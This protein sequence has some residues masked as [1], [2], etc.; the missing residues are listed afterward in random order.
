MRQLPRTRNS[1]SL[2]LAQEERLQALKVE[3]KEIAPEVVPE[4]K[5]PKEAPAEVMFLE[6]LG[7]FELRALKLRFQVKVNKNGAKLGCAVESLLKEYCIV[8][9]VDPGSPL[10]DVKAFDRVLKAGYLEVSS[11]GQSYRG[12]RAFR[13]GVIETV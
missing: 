10:K 6:H 9:R 7:R 13:E 1:A 4:V 12:G 8:K 5:A 2:P 3:A 11:N